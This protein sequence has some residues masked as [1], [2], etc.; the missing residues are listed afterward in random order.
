M[1]AKTATLTIGLSLKRQPL[2]DTRTNTAPEGKANRNALQQT[3]KQLKHR[4]S[5]VYF[6]YTAGTLA[7]KASLDSPRAPELVGY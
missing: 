7:E 6:S 5:S 2:A 1:W 4:V 3:H